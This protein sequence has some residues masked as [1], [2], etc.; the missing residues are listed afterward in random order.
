MNKSCE[1]R[2]QEVLDRKGT[3]CC[4]LIYLHVWVEVV[5][6][7]FLFGVWLSSAPSTQDILTIVTKQAVDNLQYSL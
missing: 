5:C 3:D 1:T 7:A 2:T 6:F 4:S